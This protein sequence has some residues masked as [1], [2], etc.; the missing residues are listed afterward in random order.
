MTPCKDLFRS[1]PLSHIHADR[2]HIRNAHRHHALLYKDF[3]T[4]IIPGHGVTIG[5]RPSY[6]T[7]V[8]PSD[9]CLSRC[10][11]HGDC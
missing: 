6:A 10:L 9:T 4:H 11:W 2:G 7:F 3:H 8:N 1:V 5:G